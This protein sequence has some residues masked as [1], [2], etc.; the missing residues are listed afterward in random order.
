MIAAVIPCLFGIKLGDGGIIVY[1]FNDFLPLILL[2]TPK[3]T[4]IMRVLRRASEQRWPLE[5]PFLPI[6]LLRLSIG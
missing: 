3:V 6:F 2:L 1:S 5:H 4:T